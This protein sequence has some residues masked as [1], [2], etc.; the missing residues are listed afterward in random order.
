MVLVLVALFDM[1]GYLSRYLI[2]APPAQIRILPSEFVK[3]KIS[4]TRRVMITPD[5]LFPSFCI[6]AHLPMAGG[7][8]PLQVAAYVDYF[9]AQGLF[10]EGSI[11]DAWTPS[12]KFA[13]ELGVVAVLSQQ[14]LSHPT[15]EPWEHQGDWYLS[16]VHNPKPFVEFISTSPPVSASGTFSAEWDGS[17]WL[18][19]GTAPTDGF[20]LVRQTY[21]PGWTAKAATDESFTVERQDPFWQKI[22]VA[23]G[24][25]QLALR[26]T[27]PSWKL[28]WQLAGAGLALAGVFILLRKRPLRAIQG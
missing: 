4:P 8:D 11:P 20:L 26:Y 25:V 7:Y 6:P 14:P 9:R 18:I 19:T 5:V 21:T 24:P 27:P 1:G 3:N 13:P 16:R 15:V 23:Q 12:L 10:E 28:S 2:S 22:P 17:H